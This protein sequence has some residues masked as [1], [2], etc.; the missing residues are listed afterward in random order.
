MSS[1]HFEEIGVEN[2]DHVSLEQALWPR[3]DSAYHR[4][5]SE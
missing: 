1:I 5:G 3:P 4:S 2:G